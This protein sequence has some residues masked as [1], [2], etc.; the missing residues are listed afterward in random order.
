VSTGLPLSQD[1]SIR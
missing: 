1:A